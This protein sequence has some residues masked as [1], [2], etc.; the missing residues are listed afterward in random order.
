VS[1]LLRRNRPLAW[2][3]WADLDGPHQRSNEN[4]IAVP[5][6]RVNSGRT[7]KLENN[8]LVIHD[9]SE[10]IMEFGGVSFEHQPF[11]P[12]WGCEFDV[13]LNA[14]TVQEQ[15]WGAGLA[16]SWTDPSFSSLVGTPL[17]CFWRNALNG[18][19]SI[20][21]TVLNSSSY[22]V[23][24][25]NG[26]PNPFN[27]QWHNVKMWFD[28]DKHL[29]IFVDN[30][31]YIF[32]TMPSDKRPSRGKRSLN[33][34]NQTSNFSYMRNFK[35][36][37]RPPDLTWSTTPLFQDDFNRANNSD[38]GSQWTK[39]GVNSGI[40]SNWYGSTGTSDGSRG[41]WANT[42]STSGD[43]RV[44]TRIQD[45]TVVCSSVILLRG[46]AAMNNFLG[47]DIR[48]D[49]LQML[50]GTGTL[51]NVSWTVLSGMDYTVDDNDLVA[52]CVKGDYMWVEVNGNIPLFAGGVSALCPPTNRKHGLLVTRASFVWSPAFDYYSLS[53]AA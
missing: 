40:R 41:I 29:R 17:L 1:F 12:N 46:N 11:T 28:E 51:T 9:Y 45:S 36:Y 21:V 49:R 5:W 6:K 13:F 48:G 35:L 39:V 16:P 26:V 19:D 37:D 23:L 10:T 52:A 22:T 20:R 44:D 4:P 34:L 2:A 38:V 33:F 47:V 27:G 24:I 50:H 3:G 32:W 42:D 15:F 53:T 25:Q 18:G 7:V 43:M 14:N 8:L 31:L 30:L